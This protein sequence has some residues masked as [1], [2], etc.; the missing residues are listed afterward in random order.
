[1][2]GAPIGLGFRVPCTIVS[3]WTVGGHVATE[4]FDHTSLIRFLEQRFGVMEPNISDWRR[5]ATGDL[6][7]AFQFGQARPF[8]AGNQALT[9]PSTTLTLVSAQHEVAANPAPTVP[10]VNTPPV[11]DATTRTGYLRP[12][13]SAT[14]S[15]AG[16]PAVS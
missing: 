6:T 7:S 4:T 5:Q 15:G 16:S 9:V 10:A 11:Q 1:V 3:P 8:P 2:D 13:P 12:A 14:P